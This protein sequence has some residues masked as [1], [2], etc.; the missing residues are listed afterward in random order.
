MSA[1]QP[2]VKPTSRYSVKE[3]CKFL[4]I[5]RHTLARYVEQG[6]IREGR[7][8]INGRPFYTGLEIIKLF[9]K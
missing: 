5:H 9:N 4:G 7:S 2:E 8:K 3:T 6:L 1:D